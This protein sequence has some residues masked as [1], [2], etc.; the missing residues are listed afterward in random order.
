VISR[1][2][3]YALNAVIHI[4]RHDAGGAV[5]AAALAGALDVPANY[6]SKILRDLARVGLLTSDR[7]RRGGFRLA[8][9]AGTIRLVEVVELFDPLDERRQCLLGRG[10]CSAVGSCPAHQAWKE[11]SAP[12]IRFFE[13][14]TVADLAG[15]S[16]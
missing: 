7:G 1:T 10:A 14:R 12:L 13:S 6:L 11:A 2:A 16:R 5:S 9:P 4:A 8:R 15:T 3:G